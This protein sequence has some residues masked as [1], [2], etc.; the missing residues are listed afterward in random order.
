[1]SHCGT[2]GNACTTP[3]PNAA[4]QCSSGSCDWTCQSGYEDCNGDGSDGCEL[5]TGQISG[6]GDNLASGNTCGAS[7][8][9]TGSCP[10]DGSEHVYY[11]TAPASQSYTIDT[12]ESDYDTALYVREAVCDG[13]EIACN[14]DAPGAPDLESEVTIS[15]TDGTTYAIFVDGFSGCGDYQLDIN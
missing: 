3:P 15:A 6:T 1:M 4:V 8:Q 11:W 5:K 9:Y 12:F 7:Q 14:D 2:C 13:T 10:S